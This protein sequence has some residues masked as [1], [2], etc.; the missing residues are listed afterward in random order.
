[1]NTMKTVSAITS[2][3]TPTTKTTLMPCSRDPLNRLKIA[4]GISAMMPAKMISEIPLP[5]PRAVI[6]SPIHIRNMVPPVNVVT[7]VR[8]KNHWG[9]VS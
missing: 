4:R 2:A 1:M 6:C 3:A 7:A 8:T 9:I 5:T